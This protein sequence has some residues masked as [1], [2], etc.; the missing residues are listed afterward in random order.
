MT[1]IEEHIRRAIEQ[2]EFDNLP[3]EGKPL[4]L[5]DNPYEDPEWRMA[6]RLLRESGYS[7]PWI[8][9]RKEISDRLNSARSGLK[10]AWEWRRRNLTGSQPDG[11]V[12]E[13][14]QRAVQAF[15]EKIEQINQQISTYNLAA[16]SSRFQL[17]M[18][19]A[20]RELE[21]TRSG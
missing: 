20:D 13:Q 3:G 19:D 2:G 10:R 4:T 16:P 9:S 14:W 5:D 6:Y 7:L 8:E 11:L 12:D 21:K 1:G 17:M 18:L 15:Y